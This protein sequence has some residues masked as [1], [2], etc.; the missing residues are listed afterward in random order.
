MLF[1]IFYYTTAQWRSGYECRI[2][3]RMGI[4]AIYQQW[5]PYHPR[6]SSILHAFNFTTILRL[7]FSSVLNRVELSSSIYL[8]QYVL[9][10]LR[11]IYV[12]YNVRIFEKERVEQLKRKVR[13]MKINDE[14]TT[15]ASQTR[16]CA[17]AIAADL[18]FY[19]FVF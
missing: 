10:G 2:R 15:A 13:A 6:S 9:C 4:H 7:L 12:Q 19:L 3:I 18:Y 11:A 17:H 5:A 1:I 14:Y 8:Q 16:V